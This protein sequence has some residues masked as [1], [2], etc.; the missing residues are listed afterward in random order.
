LFNDKFGVTIVTLHF[1]V[2]ELRIPVTWK[3]IVHD[4]NLKITIELIK[5]KL[6]R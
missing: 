4:K 6:N 3:Y 2:A 1:A 5:F